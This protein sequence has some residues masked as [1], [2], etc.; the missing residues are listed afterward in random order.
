M[1]TT[2]FKISVSL[3]LILISSIPV[4]ANPERLPQVCTT[5]CHLKNNIDFGYAKDEYCGSCHQFV[6]E[7]KLSIGLMEQSHNPNTCKLC[8]TVKD[9]GSFHTLHKNVTE[10]CN[11]CHGES[12]SAV[13]ENTFNQCGGCHGGKIHEIHEEK[14]DQICVT[15][16]EVIPSTSPTTIESKTIVNRAY[17]KVVN[18]QKYTILEL[19]KGLFGWK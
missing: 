13:P 19:I 1:K 5:G 18:Y 11:R 8:H 6:S 10:S 17:A 4:L 9:S 14:I 2:L 12:G 15:C 7:G 3:I 16:H